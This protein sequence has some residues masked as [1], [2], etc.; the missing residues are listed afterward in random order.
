MKAFLKSAFAIVLTILV[1]FAAIAYY[2]VHSSREIIVQQ[3]EESVRNLVHV[4]TGKIDMLMTSVETAVAAQKWSVGEHLDDPD[5]MY[6]ITRELVESTP[7]IVGSTVA[8]RPDFYREKG[9]EYAPYTC[10]L[11]DGS[12]QSF[13]LVYTNGYHS[14][15]WYTGCA[16]TRHPI[17]SQPYF[18]DG[19]AKIMMSTYSVPIFDK[20]TNLCAVFTADLSLRRLMDY[21][22]HIRPYRDS[23]V[24]VKAGNKVLV[25]ERDEAR[26]R[27]G[28]YEGR[29]VGFRDTA[30]NGWSVEI[31]CP[32]VEI[33][34]RPKQL[35]IR[36]A[37]FSFMGLLL[38]FAI[39]YYY[40]KRLA[41]TSALRER[42]STELGTA[43]SIQSCIAPRD[44]PENVFALLRPARE[45]G[46]DLYDFAVRGGKLY[47]VIG[48]ASGKGV[49]AALFSFMAGTVFRMACNLQLNPGEIAGRMNVALAHN[50]E[51]S[52]FVTAFVGALDLKTGELEFGC[53][54][55]NPPV[56]IAPD[57]TA[58]FLPVRRGPPA[59]AVAGIYYDLQKTTLAPGSKI[60]VYTDGVTEAEKSD[61]AQYGDVRLLAYA[62]SN[63]KASPVDFAMGLVKD[64]DRFVAGA[65]QSDDITLMT[66]AL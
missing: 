18:D 6:R 50:N 60:L 14:Q 63:A 29:V 20:A 16:R 33:L 8:F 1:I 2:L 36:I 26:K 9:R 24:I 51:M 10:Q 31:G 39:A 42:L 22:T 5:Y 35:V 7:Y 58:S 38:I 62:A 48:D 23:Y 66:I 49:P 11:A 40:T 44:F 61:H 52:M 41:R 12:T 21:V 28:F 3:A 46:G 17:W 34:R 55:H 57:G 37:V 27:A 25:G 15:G 43:H 53:A 64:V 56:V 65:E 19:G 47:F 13:L 30:K 54:G 45:V 32:L 59:G 4:T